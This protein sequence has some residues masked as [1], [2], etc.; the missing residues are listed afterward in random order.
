MVL[1]LEKIPVHSELIL[2]TWNIPVL[3][4]YE[5]ERIS[6]G[7]VGRGIFS[8]N[9][10]EKEDTVIYPHGYDEPSEYQVNYQKPVTVNK[11][12]T[13]E[14]E[15]KDYFIVKDEYMS[16]INEFRE[17]VED[18]FIGGM[19]V[20]LEKDCLSPLLR[21][22]L[23]NRFDYYITL[24]A[25]GTRYLMFLAKNGVLFFI[26]RSTNIFYLRKPDSSIVNLKPG[27]PF[28]FDGE[29]IQ[30][31]DGSFEFLIFDVLFYPDHGELRNW[32]PYPYHTRYLIMENALKFLNITDFDIS[33]KSWFPIER[34]DSRLRVPI[35][36]KPDTREIYNYVIEET[37][38][39]RMSQKRPPLQEDGLILQPFE[40]YYVPFREWNVYN[41]IQFKWKPPKQLTVDFKIKADP[42]NKGIWWLLTSTGQNYDV[43]QKD[44]SNVHAII[45]ISS[46]PGYKKL[47]S[48]GDVVECKLKEGRN[49]NG[50]IFVPIRKREDKTTGNSL[51]TVMSTIEVV[52]KPFNLDILAP[53]IHALLTGTQPEEFIKF[54]SLSKLILCSI[55]MF[56][57]KND[58]SEIKK[59]YN[60]YFGKDLSG[61]ETLAPEPEPELESITEPEIVI[62]ENNDENYQQSDE[63]FSF[64]VVGRV[65]QETRERLKNLRKNKPTKTTTRSNYELELRIYPYIKKGKK[66]DIKRFTYF[67]LLDFLK[68][69]DSRQMYE[70]TLDLI[71]SDGLETFRSTYA[72]STLQN[73]T[74]MKK[75]KI[76]EFKS[77][78]LYPEKKLYNNL[79]Y[80]VSLSTEEQSI[81]TV[82]LKTTSAKNIK[83]DLIRKKIRSSFY[84]YYK[85]EFL[86][87]IDLTKVLSI[88]EH[89]NL[90]TSVETYELECEYIGPQNIPFQMFLDSMNYV[91]TLIL[92]NTSYC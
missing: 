1:T 70:Y 67:Y 79:T 58:I 66:L 41:N 44:G 31:P 11:Y 3:E 16:L 74:N 19:P 28:L 32:M 48:E 45:D 56:F 88:R 54:Y 25:D 89:R 35:K 75:T 37:N 49:P 27:F 47:Y 7:Q 50:N 18:Q 53:A 43:K 2:K 62:I 71:S 51:Q 24:K 77:T 82:G 4:H 78:P 61:I 39:I 76:L 73:P 81:K 26:D 40:G 86:W 64:G 87:R 84:P 17:K 68:K 23:D 6:R 42:E 55:D 59:I 85:G 46:N 8:R 72:D 20:Q 63:E 33:L 38:K 22:D 36:G 10:F 9:V 14:A 57:T 12:L 29:L 5:A 60:I 34:I 90:E 80:K 30:H 13:S 91:Y 92:F 15:N 65:P 21:R 83:Y 69:R 52:N